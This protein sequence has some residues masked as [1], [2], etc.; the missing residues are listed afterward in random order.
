MLGRFTKAVSSGF[1]PSSVHS[2]R[3]TEVSWSKLR[4]KTYPSQ[5]KSSVDNSSDWSGALKDSHQ[6]RAVRA[7]RLQQST[8]RASQ[9]AMNCVTTTGARASGF[10][11]WKSHCST[12]QLWEKQ[13]RESSACTI[14]SGCQILPLQAHASTFIPVNA[15]VTLHKWPHRKKL[16]AVI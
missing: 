1:E 11:I 10:L 2:R 16:Q 7:S 9:S 14:L 13:R 4:D 8:V 6:R 5:N 12:L 3:T 15:T